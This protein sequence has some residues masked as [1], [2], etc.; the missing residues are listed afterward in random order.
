MHTLDPAVFPPQPVRDADR[1]LVLIRNRLSS[2]LGSWPGDVTIG[3]PYDRWLEAPRVQ[4]DEV[5][6]LVRI[7]LRAIP[8]V[9]VITLSASVGRK[10]EVQG[11]I[12]IQTSDGIVVAG[13]GGDI[14]GVSSVPAWYLSVRRRAC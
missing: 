8:G 10:I 6:G 3:L 9:R 5:V 1:V 14:F 7:Q 4:A 11:E 2:R 12:E 13:L